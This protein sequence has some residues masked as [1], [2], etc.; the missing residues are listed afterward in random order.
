[1]K[2]TLII[3]NRSR[4]NGSIQRLRRA[5]GGN[6]LP[7]AIRPKASMAR[8]VRQAEQADVGYDTNETKTNGVGGVRQ[9]RQMR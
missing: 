9:M 6:D 3:P 4:D 5:Q 8:L 1:M 2:I 7:N